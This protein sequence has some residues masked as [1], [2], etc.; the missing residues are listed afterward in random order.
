[1]HVI[2][3]CSF[4][5]DDESEF[6]EKLEALEQLGLNPQVESESEDEDA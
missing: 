4:S 6:H 5:Y 1:M 3:S 2:L